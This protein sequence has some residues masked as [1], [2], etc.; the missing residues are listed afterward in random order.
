MEAFR[1]RRMTIFTQKSR[2][3][4]EDGAGLQL[5]TARPFMAG[6]L[7]HGHHEVPDGTAEDSFVPGGTGILFGAWFYK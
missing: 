2:Q 5:R 1:G 4:P 7:A 3:T 6:E